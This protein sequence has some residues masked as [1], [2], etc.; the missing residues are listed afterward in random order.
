M[1]VD[2]T[3]SFFF[4]SRAIL[5]R[6]GIPEINPWGFL[7]PLTGS[8][9]ASVAA[10][11]IVVWLATMLIGR[12]PGADVSLNWAEKVFLQHVRVFLNQGE[13]IG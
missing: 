8:V 5:S 3:E 9:W 13:L 12:R 4:D 2:F 10:A 1:A 7:Y 11:L 6:K